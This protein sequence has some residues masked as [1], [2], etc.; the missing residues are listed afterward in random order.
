MEPLTPCTCGVAK[1]MMDTSS[2]R[3][4]M[5]FLIGLTDVFNQAKNKILLLDPLHSVNKAFSMIL[6][7]E[8]QK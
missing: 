2:R 6:K 7:V 3:K 5:Q 4:L 8:A 1:E